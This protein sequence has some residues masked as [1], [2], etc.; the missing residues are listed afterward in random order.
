[1]KRSIAIALSVTAL[2]LSV[3][4]GQVGVRAVASQLAGGFSLAHIR[5]PSSSRPKCSFE[6]CG[7]VELAKAILDQPFHYVG[8]GSQMY[9]FE[10]LDHKVVLKFVK[11]QRLRV[12]AWSEKLPFPSFLAKIHAQ[13][14]LKKEMKKRRLFKSC[15]LAFQELRHEAALVFCHLGAGE[16]FCSPVRLNGPLGRSFVIPIEEYDF[17]IQRKG[18]PFVPYLHGLLEKG[19]REEAFTAIKSAFDLIKN[20]HVKGIRDYDAFLSKNAGFIDGRACFFDIGQFAHDQSLKDPAIHLHEIGVAMLKLNRELRKLDP[21]LA[22]YVNELIEHER[23]M[24]Q[25]E[26]L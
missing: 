3:A 8:Q 17:I 26:H 1:M 21:Q 6:E 9:I 18:E 10:S 11:H 13:K 7:D 25:N 19:E 16:R 2:I 22:A 5:S 24:K 15:R 14:M 12:P 23:N 4:V 20:R